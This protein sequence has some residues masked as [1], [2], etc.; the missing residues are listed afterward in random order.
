MRL[1]EIDAKRIA[2]LEFEGDT[3]WAIDVDRIPSG[4]E[5]LQGMETKARHIHLFGP[6]RNIEPIQPPKDPLMHLR[7]DPRRPTSLPQI[8][9]RL[10]S[11]T[12]NR[13]TKM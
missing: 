12:S 7:I 3:P 4:L 8:G 9:Q 11:E 1:L 2:F 5:S 13:H 6:Y 10:A